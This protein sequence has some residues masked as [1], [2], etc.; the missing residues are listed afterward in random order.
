MGEVLQEI[1][2]ELR[3]FRSDVEKLK[4]L[5]EESHQWIRILVENK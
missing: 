1:L 2:Q 4:P 3:D 5:V